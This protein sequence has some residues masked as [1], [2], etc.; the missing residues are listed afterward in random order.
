MT[1]PSGQRAGLLQATLAYLVWGFLPLYF[2]LLEPAGSVE[3]VAWRVL[4]SVVFSAI[5][6]TFI[7]HGWRTFAGLI[8]RPRVLV[9]LFA[10]GAFVLVNWLIYVFATLTGHV[11][12]AS[13]GYFINPIVTVLLGVLILGER[14]RG[15]QWAAVAVSAV[16]VLI[17]AIGYGRFP[18]ISL[19]LALSFGLY[20]LVKKRVGASVDAVAGFTVETL[21]LAPAGFALLVWVHLVDGGIVFGN[22]GLPNAL[23]LGAAG[24]VT[25][26]PLLL[27]AAAARR[28]S[29]VAIGLL[30]FI[31]PV[32]QLLIGALVLGEPMPVERWLGFALVWVA[33]VISTIDM[34]RHARSI[35]RAAPLPS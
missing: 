9:T 3:I 29:L 10:A 13:L 22:A 15:M 7:R 16:A 14:L 30:Q 1:T 27:F 11:V 23:L 34:I 24:I 31:T 2:I 33:L 5:L 19:G 12:E 17:I 18:W 28:L 21:L 25:A 20:G 4:F 35:R 26:V 8:R 32:L 6:L